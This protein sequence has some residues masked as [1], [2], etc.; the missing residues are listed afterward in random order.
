[1]SS[2][3]DAATEVKGFVAGQA[4]ND[5]CA[6]APQQ[7]TQRMRPAAAPVSASRLLPNA[8]D[9]LIAPDSGV[10]GQ[11]LELSGDGLGN[12][13][14]VEGLPVHR[15]EGLQHGNVLKANGKNAGTERRAASLTQPAASVIPSSGLT[16]ISQAE[17]TLRTR[18][19]AGSSSR[20]RARGGSRVG[21]R[22]AH[23]TA[24]VSSSVLTRHGGS[25]QLFRQSKR[26]ETS[27]GPPRQHPTRAGDR[28][29]AGPE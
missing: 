22:A 21:S 7:A 3:T 29:P 14:P 17:A 10:V 9:A 20:E 19:Y 2:L 18:S 13:Y 8:T 28:W 25:A 23:S 5:V 6:E 1:M 12:Q 27:R 15:R 26:R 11:Q 24:Q 4:H 16:A